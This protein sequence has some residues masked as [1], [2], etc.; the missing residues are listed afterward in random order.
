M[1]LTVSETDF[2]AVYVFEYLRVEL[3]P[4]KLK[5]QA[6]GF[7]DTDLRFLLEAYIMANPPHDALVRDGAGNLVTEFIFGR[8][9]SDPPDPPW[10]SREEAQK[11]NAELLA[12]W[13]ALRAERVEPVPLE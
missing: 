8:Q 9:D 12:E 13:N 4:A 2:L 10:S 3:S 11:R 1:P 5:L 7:V 6:R